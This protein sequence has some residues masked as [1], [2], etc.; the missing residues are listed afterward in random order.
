MWGKTGLLEPSKDKT[1][2]KIRDSC[3][4]G[5]N[6]V[7]HERQRAEEQESSQWPVSKTQLSYTVLRQPSGRRRTYG[8]PTLS[9]EKTRRIS[10][11]ELAGEGRKLP[12]RAAKKQEARKGVFLFLHGMPHLKW[13]D[14]PEQAGISRGRHIL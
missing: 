12:R 7:V 11:R 6:K 8:S 1:K 14:Y 13:K 2:Q 4:W 10:E 3:V 9:T 5:I